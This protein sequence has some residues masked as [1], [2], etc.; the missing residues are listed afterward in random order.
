MDI[1]TPTTGL[2]N[3]DNSTVSR[4]ALLLL[5]SYLLIAVLAVVLRFALIDY[6]YPVLRNRDEFYRFLNTMLIRHDMP[7]IAEHYGVYDFNP[8]YNYE[9]FP[10]VQMWVHAP[11]QRIVEANV[12][13]PF[14]PDY[15]MGA[16]YVSVA[17]S[18]VTSLLVLWMAW[19]LAR[20]MGKYPAHRP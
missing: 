6:Y 5:G 13:F 17:V 19:Y 7:E 15:I 8:N 9:G 4:Y 16:R 3:R 11:V 10:P 18:V 20:P 12:P 2:Q 14:P 1:S